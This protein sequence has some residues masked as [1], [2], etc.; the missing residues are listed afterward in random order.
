MSACSLH[1]RYAGHYTAYAK[2]GEKWY[3]FDDTRCVEVSEER[4]LNDRG[5]AYMLFYRR[6]EDERAA[7]A[8][9]DVGSAAAG[10]AAGA[11]AG[12]DGG[13]FMEVD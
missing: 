7:A 6:C 12:D 9:A 5:S 10:G 13:S 3:L 8:A 2:N 4:V 1:D 11:G